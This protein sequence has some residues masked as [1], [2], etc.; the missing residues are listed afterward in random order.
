MRKIFD[1]LRPYGLYIAWAAALAATLGSLYF[2]EIRGWAP[3]VLCWYQRIAMYPL[4]LILG[5]GIIKE[6]PNIRNYALPLAAIGAGIA[7]YHYLLQLGIIT[8]KLAPCA[9]G[10]SCLTRYET[11]L[12]FVTL[13]LLAFFAFV[14]VIVGTLIYKKG[15]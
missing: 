6:D 8:E 1:S 7:F 5:V 9:E 12:G 15:N 14:A 13:P 11:W 4:V 10:I 2:S 3:C